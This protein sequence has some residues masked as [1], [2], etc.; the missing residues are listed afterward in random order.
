MSAEHRD[1]QQQ[2][3]R[4]VEADAHQAPVP[5][6][7]ASRSPSE[8]AEP[9]QAVTVVER[10]L[11]A[12]HGEDRAGRSGPTARRGS[13]GRSVTGVPGARSPRAGAPPRR[14]RPERL[15]RRRRCRAR[16]STHRRRTGR[17]RS[18][19]A[20]ADPATTGDARRARSCSARLP[21]RRRCDGGCGPARRRTGARLGRG[22]RI[23]DRRDGVDAG[24]VCGRERDG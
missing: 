14:G 5:G 15:D 11:D 3:E 10:P 23:G 1:E 21:R 7:R 6:P 24:Q 19:P 18:G 8:R 22:I 4:R 9:D 16:S 12:Q 2:R 17:R 13:S 20:P